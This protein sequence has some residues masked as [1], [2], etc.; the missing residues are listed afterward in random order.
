MSNNPR[1][2]AASRSSR[3]DAPHADDA[4][5]LSPQAAAEHP[6]G[7]P[8]LPGI[9]A[10]DHLGALDQAARYRHDQRHGHVGRVFGENP[11]RI[12]H[13]NAPRHRRFHVDIVN[14]GAKIGDELQL[15]AGL[16]ENGLV[17]AVRHRG[18]QHIRSLDRLDEF[19]LSHGLIGCIELGLEKL[20]HPRFNHLGQLP[21][22]DNDRPV[23]THGN[24]L[25]CWKIDIKLTQGGQS[26]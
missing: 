15:L 2:D 8:A 22:H 19:G 17:D 24:A 9:V 16:H 14:P 7:R 13:R 5:A 3:A 10:A 23:L 26:C 20:H 12:G 6:G 25:Q 11:R 1:L 18:H 4:D 21:R